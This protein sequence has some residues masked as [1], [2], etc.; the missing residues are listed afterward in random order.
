MLG[1]KLRHHV[2][3]ALRF[4]LGQQPL[5]AKAPLQRE[6]LVRIGGQLHEPY[7]ALLP[8]EVLHRL[9][10]LRLLLRHDLS[11]GPALAGWDGR[12]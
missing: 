5:Q 12:W 7:N 2:A 6:E 4:V 8:L 11:E 3:P 10:R 9:R 1:L